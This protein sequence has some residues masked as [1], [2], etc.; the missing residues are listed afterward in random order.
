MYSCVRVCGRGGLMWNMCVTCGAWLSLHLWEQ[1]MHSFDASL[2]VQVLLPV[3]R[4][5]ARFF[6]EYMFEGEQVAPW[7]I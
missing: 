3:Y 5:T 2:L 1:L 7:V 4:S 6:V